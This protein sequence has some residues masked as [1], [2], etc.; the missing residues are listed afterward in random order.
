MSLVGSEGASSET[1]SAEMVETASDS[2]SYEDLDWDNLPSLEDAQGESNEGNTEESS[3]SDQDV[4]SEEIGSEP[5][6]ESGQAASEVE[7]DKSEDQSGEQASIEENSEEVE[8]KATPDLFEVKV[9]GKV[10]EVSLDDLKSNYSG[11]VAYDKKFTELDRERQAYKQEVDQIN[12]YVNELGDTMKN[13]SLLE[14]FYKVG[15][16]VGMAPHAIKQSLIKEILPEI[17]RMSELSQSEIDLEYQRQESQY[18]RDKAE[19]DKQKLEQEQIQRDLYAKIDGIRETN[20]ISEDEWNNA[21]SYLKEHLNE[22]V[23]PELVGNYVNFNR[24]GSRAESLLK[25]FDAALLDDKDVFNNVQDVIY[26][27]S[28]LSDD[29]FRDILKDEYGKA[30]ESVVEQQVEKAVEKK[31]PAKR[32]KKPDESKFQ[33]EEFLDWDDIE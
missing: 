20:S 28:H 10:E 13:A 16:L 25:E 6:E 7:S 12:S 4:S 17:N 18:L 9:N 11:K 8:A 32:Q 27:Y 23:T 26:E 30:K 1:I 19:F 21:Q 24:A 15:E 31:A 22:E 5:S 33:P 14:G 29:D 3:E 2:V